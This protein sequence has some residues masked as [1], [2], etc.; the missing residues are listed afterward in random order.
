[1]AGNILALVTTI[2]LARA[3]GTA[4]YGEL[5]RM[6]SVF[7]ILIVPATALQA[8]AARD[9]TLGRLGPASH[10][11]ATL[12]GW[13]VRIML[14]TFGVLVACMLLRHQLADL[15]QVSQPWAAALVIPSGFLWTAVAL[16]RGVLL[17]VGGYRPVAMSLIGEQGF[18][19]LFGLAA[20]LLGAEV[21]LIFFCSVPLATIPVI[22][23][24]GVLTRR[25][26]GPSDR[27]PI[28]VGLRDLASRNPVP[29]AALTL[30]AVLQNADVIA[31]G[32]FFNT[33]ISGAYAQAAVAAKGVVWIAIGLGLYLLPEA[34]REAAKGVDARHLLG[35]TSA[36]LMLVA[37]PILAIF[38]FFPEQI[39][40]LVF[41]D[42]AELAAPALPW[43]AGAMTCLSISYLALQF[44]IALGRRSFL[45]LLTIGAVAVPVVVAIR[46]SSLESVAIGLLILDAILAALMLAISFSARTAGEHSFADGEAEAFALAEASA[47]AEAAIP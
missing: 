22:F 19:L 13:L 20:A 27:K 39:L 10:A 34:A 8:A 28:R 29:V 1:M 21:G 41:G 32:H 7:T 44:L 24:T 42:Q 17:G 38:A 36:L 45:V 25:R 11:I 18:R 26:L 9:M 23:M 31:V 30:F 14:L 6:V 12:Q 15:L 35:R 3:L 47:A 16:Q 37:V 4:D 2:A 40:T 43:L 46:D 5:A 33:T